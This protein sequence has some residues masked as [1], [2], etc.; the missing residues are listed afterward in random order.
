MGS[1]GRNFKPKKAPGKR[2]H[3]TTATEAAILKFRNSKRWIQC[4]LYKLEIEPL[5]QYPKCQTGATDVH[6][7]D[8]LAEEFP[9]FTNAVNLENLRSLCK[10]CHGK[11]SMMEVSG[12]RQQ[13]KDIF[14]NGEVK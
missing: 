1:M 2:I 3:Y 14:R 4:R 12:M 7:I 8:T 13:A 6:H 11:I 5:C 10:K 9:F